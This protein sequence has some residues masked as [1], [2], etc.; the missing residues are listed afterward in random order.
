MLLWR[1]SLRFL[2]RHPAQ[3]ALAVSGIALGV[4]IVIGILLT[5]ASARQAFADSLRSVFGTAS[6]FVVA[7]DGEDF[8]E[9]VL[10]EVRRQA[11]ALAPSAVITG[12]LRVD[13]DGSVQALQILGVDALNLRGATGADDFALRDFLNLP[14]AMLLTPRT[15]RRFAL[16][17]GG[18]LAVHGASASQKLRLLATLH[19]SDETAPAL[20]DDIAV[21]DIATAQEVLG[22]AGFITRI[23]LDANDDGSSAAALAALARALPPALQVIDAGRQ[24][25][26]ARTLTD[27]F[28]TNLDALSLLAL[29]VGGFMIYNTMSFLVMQRQSLFARLRALGVTRAALARLIVAEALVLG[30]LGGVLGCALGYALASALMAPVGQTL[31]DHYFAT[32]GGQLTFPAAL[33]VLGVALATLTPLLAAALPAWSALRADP[34]HAARYSVSADS[35]ARGLAQA[36]WVGLLGG[37]LAVALLGLSSRSL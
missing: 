29:L 36:A 25:R 2:T 9:R 23:E 22:K 15:A 30:L 31:R 6:H 13:V 1:A 27:A 4:A 21:V 28:Y 16:A 26:G 8:D 17:P 18:E 12:T 7:V 10:A 24:A 19:A 33:A 3:C 14:G 20:G 37:L 35:A 11:P 34:A 32:G 5:Q